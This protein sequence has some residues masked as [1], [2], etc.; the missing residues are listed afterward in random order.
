[1]KEF[2]IAQT[3]RRYRGLRSYSV[4]KEMYRSEFILCVYGDV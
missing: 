3:S 2:N 4:F 1:M